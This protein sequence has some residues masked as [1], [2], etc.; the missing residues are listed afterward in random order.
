MVNKCIKF[1]EDIF[2]NKNVIA[3]VKVCFANDNNNYSADDTGV[4]TIPRHFVQYSRVTMR[5]RGG[6]IRSDD[7]G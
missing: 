3:N 5:Y 1:H 2:N 7:Q 6:G 4:M